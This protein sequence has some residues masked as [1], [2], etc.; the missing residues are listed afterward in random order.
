MRCN[1]L[2]TRLEVVSRFRELMPVNSRG[3]GRG[4]VVVKAGKVADVLEHDFLPTRKCV[5]SNGVVESCRTERKSLRALT[6][7]LCLFLFVFA[8]KV[9]VE[10]PA[11]PP[12][13]AAAAADSARRLQGFRG[14][15][16]NFK[17][18]SR[19]RQVRLRVTT[20]SLIPLPGR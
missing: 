13:A 17:L 5:K 10:E 3:E 2:F 9:L 18:I 11:R 19:T 6:E 8:H 12:P 1:L 15:S 20:S 16:H 7:P 14:A 4:D